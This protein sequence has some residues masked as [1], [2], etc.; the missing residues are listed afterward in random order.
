MRQ[1]TAAHYAIIPHCVQELQARVG[2]WGLR[3]LLDHYRLEVGHTHRLYADGAISA[4]SKSRSQE[5]VVKM[6]DGTISVLCHH[7]PQSF[8]DSIPRIYNRHSNSVCTICIYDLQQAL[9]LC[10]APACTH[11]HMPSRATTY[12][13]ACLQQGRVAAE[14]AW[15]AARHLQFQRVGRHGAGP[16]ARRPR[17]R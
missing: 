1:F 6:D 3:I 7:T 10:V 16:G 17:V 9:A 2:A 11:H 8:I 15:P 14:A 4:I 5:W 13:P 12:R